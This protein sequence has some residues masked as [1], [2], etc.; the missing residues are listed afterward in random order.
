MFVDP[1]LSKLCSILPLCDFER[2]ILRLAISH[3]FRPSPL[4]RLLRSTIYRYILSR[5]WIIALFSLRFPLRLFITL[6]HVFDVNTSPRQPLPD[7][8]ISSSAPIHPF[9]PSPR[10]TSPIPSLYVTSSPTPSFPSTLRLLSDDCRLPLALHSHIQR[11]DFDPDFVATLL[12]RG[13]TDDVVD[14][15]LDTG[16]T[17]AITP[18]R[19]DFIEYHAGSVGNVQTVNGPTAMIGYG[20][21]RWTLISEDGSLSHL[22]VP[23][24]HVPASKVRLLS[25]QDFCLYAGL[26]RSRDQYGGNSNYFWMN[27]NSNGTRFQCPIDPRSNLPVALAKLPCHQDG[28]CTTP[29]P[30]VDSP[31]TCISC[32]RHSIATLSVFDETN[33]NIT[34]AQKELLLWH[35]RLGHLG[36]SHVQSLMRPRVVA[37]GLPDIFQL[38]RSLHRSQTSFGQD[39]QASTLRRLSSRPCQTPQH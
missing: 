17:F 37:A 13:I 29:A 11:S 38:I 16:C 39:L 21:V 35:A 10:L 14:I 12:S 24:H 5:L 6:L 19:K 36:F 1:Q 27:S 23:C 25:P 30:H 32:Q 4:G 34:S 3:L 18:D 20:L 2:R 8:L 33:Q 15:I 28:Q 31:P 9:L 22:I 26:D 7:I